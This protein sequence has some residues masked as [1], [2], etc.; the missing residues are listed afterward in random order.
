MK[1]KYLN[2]TLIILLLIIWGNIIYK[3]FGRSKTKDTQAHIVGANM[4][5]HYAVAKDTFILQLNNRDP[6]KVSKIRK[7]TTVTRSI[8]IIKNNQPIK[9]VI[10][11]N[12]EY[13]GFVKSVS[14]KTKLVLVKVNGKL[15][16]KREKDKIESLTIIKA[17]SDSITVS[18]N[19]T[20]KTIKRL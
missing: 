10:W 17:Y 18:L 2:S 4:P 20:I 19:K 11:P 13:Y 12:I 14:N 15:L 3:Y 9:P 1:K 7:V 16:K 5:I 8:R 6:F